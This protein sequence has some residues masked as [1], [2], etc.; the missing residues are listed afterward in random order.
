MSDIELSI[1]DV[2]KV[3]ASK[4]KKGFK[5]ANRS[6]VLTKENGEEVE[7]TM[8]SL[9]QTFK[10]GKEELKIRSEK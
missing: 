8:F 9:N 6:I 3:V 4:I 5:G 2:K 1:M 7:V 10:G